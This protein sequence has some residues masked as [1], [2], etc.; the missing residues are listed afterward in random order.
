VL[1]CVRVICCSLPGFCALACRVLADVRRRLSIAL[2][3]RFCHCVGV[4]VLMVGWRGYC[5]GVLA[6]GVS[7]GEGDAADQ[8]DDDEEEHVSSP[9][10]AD[11]LHQAFAEG[12]LEF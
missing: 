2:I 7:V 8:D 9:A 10:P 1:A 5:G 11:D 4:V 12:R 6:T 3:N